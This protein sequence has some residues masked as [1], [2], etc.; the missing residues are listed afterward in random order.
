[1]FRFIT[2]RPDAEW[3][4]LQHHIDAAKNRKP[5]TR[6]SDIV[7]DFGPLSCTEKSDSDSSLAADPAEAEKS[8]ES[9]VESKVRK[10]LS[11]TNESDIWS[12]SRSPETDCH[13]TN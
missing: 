10:A 12:E 11:L 3:D 7:V 8:E 9:K 4:R 5:G 1:M 6:T 2:I 13:K